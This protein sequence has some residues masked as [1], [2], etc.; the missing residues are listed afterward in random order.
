LINDTIIAKCD[1]VS[2]ELILESDDDGRYVIFNGRRYS[3]IKNLFDTVEING[4]EY[5]LSYSGD[6]EYPYIGMIATCTLDDDNVLYFK[7]NTLDDDGNVTGVRKVDKVDDAFEYSYTLYKEDDEVIYKIADEYIVHSYNGVSIGNSDYK[8]LQ[9]YEYEATNIEDGEGEDVLSYEYISV[10]QNETYKLIVSDTVGNNKILC[11]IDINIINYDGSAYRELVNEIINTL[12]TST[13]CVLS[14]KEN[15]FGT[16]ELD[17]FSWVAGAI[18]KSGC[19]STYELSEIQDNIKILKYSIYTNLP[20][21]LSRKSDYSMNQDDLVTLYHYDDKEE[22][23][24]NKMVDME[25]DLYMPIIVGSNND[26]Q[27]VNS[28]EFILHFRTRDLDNNWQIYNDDDENDDGVSLTGNHNFSNW[29]I[30]D[31]YTYNSVSKCI[32][33]DDNVA[34]F[35][36]NQK[37]KYSDL[38]GF[39]YF[40]TDD[41]KYEQKKLTNSFLRLTYYD[42]MNPRTQNMLGTSTVFFDMN[43]FYDVLYG[44]KEYSGFY[45]DVTKLQEQSDTLEIQYDYKVNVLSEFYRL[46]GVEDDM[47]YYL[48]APNYRLDSKLIVNNPYLNTSGSSD[49]FNAYILKYFADK[50]VKQTIY[51]KFEFFHAGK[52]SRIP[53]IIPT[54]SDKNAISSWSQS[55][56]DEMKE[57]YALD[58]IYQRLY[59]PIEISY[60]QDLKRFVYNI[61]ANNNYAN[62]IVNGDKLTF[63]LFELKTKTSY[64]S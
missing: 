64:S 6:T 8:I 35:N 1:D 13:T 28:I 48:D 59:V 52:G 17:E 39:L 60:N 19:T 24:V 41:V 57:G 11:D 56:L 18:N 7:V 33:E 44:E 10:K 40:T 58:D 9:K 55:L 54:S 12:T 23:Y 43:R 31:Y 38:L 20:V 2:K 42:S 21:T 46:I 15:A 53:F 49:G 34:I 3:E 47:S 29:F 37:I 16:S 32:D 26:T 50:N 4:Y 61:S 22:E 62:A 30:T 14:K 63:N 27:M 51:V 45:K 36:F 5:R 25:K